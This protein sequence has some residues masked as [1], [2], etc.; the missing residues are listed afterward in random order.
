MKHLLLALPLIA[1]VAW[2]G[3][4]YYSGAQT[5][6][7][8]SRILEQLNA[9][10]KD[11]LVFESTEYNAGVMESTAITEVRSAEN[12]DKKIH[13]YLKYQINHSL[14]SVASENPRFGA[15]SIITTL[16]I[17][18]SLSNDDKQLIQ[19]FENG[20]PLI[21][22][23]EVAVDGATSS[24]I[25]IN[26]LDHK[27]D[28]KTIQS[29]GTVINLATTADGNVTGDSTTEE[30]MFSKGDDEKANL[31]NVTLKFNLNRTQSDEAAL[32]YL[33]D[34]D[35]EATMDEFSFVEL[36]ETSVGISDFYSKISTDKFGNGTSKSPFYYLLHLDELNIEDLNFKELDYESTVGEFRIKDDANENAT[37][38][39]TV[40]RFN[41]SRSEGPDS[42]S[43]FFYDAIL[44]SSIGD[45]SFVEDADKKADMS[46]FI[47][48]ANFYYAI[49]ME[50]LDVKDL[51]FEDI[52]YEVKL[53]EF[54]FAEGS[55]EKVS[56][57]D[58]AMHIN[59]NKIKQAKNQ[60]PFFFDLA[61]E[62][63]M[64]TLNVVESGKQQAS[65]E[66]AHYVLV[67]NLSAD[68]PYSK[69]GMG[70]DSMDIESIP[71]QSFLVDMALTGFSTTE[72]M[73]N[74][75]FYEDLKAAKN[76]EEI[77][78]SEKSIEIMR[79]SIKPDTK[80]AIK[81]N[82]KSSEGNG[83][84]WIDFRF[85]GNGTDDGYTG[86]VT[87]GDLAKSFAGSAVVNIDKSALMLTPLGD[88]L[89]HPMAQAYLTITED[90]VTLNANL[91]KM[92]L[93]LNEQ[94]IPLDLM[95][96]DMLD[97]PLESLKTMLQ[98]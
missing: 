13:F 8:Y 59:I 58:M 91:E 41:I 32:A 24:Q 47:I 53:D 9:L 82:A 22:T 61:L 14:V 88:M 31:S 26:A 44:E 51:N 48:Y 97:M 23:T 29:S 71:L 54:N 46:D 1:S 34:L 56:S 20:E 84:T 52:N 74:Q 7:T 87:T 78:F 81:F 49:N 50:N 86:M 37:T 67:Q 4:T 19:S 11:E 27:E 35:W 90:K 96:G 66:H 60:S 5:E 72:M 70:V 63:K 73:A 43:P 55:D 12:S 89:E 6:A 92:V 85:T 94:V 77:L 79:A 75:S 45:F 64:G 42:D 16:M 69:F 95:A 28:D 36:P 17:D 57:S 68:E 76:P 33:Y 38:S 98:K 18:K 3:T 83:N 80:L 15:A 40:M 10:S 30:I 2:A 39:D 93:K 65:I 62:G 25:I 21:A